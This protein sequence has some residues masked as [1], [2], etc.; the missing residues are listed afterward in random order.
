MESVTQVI[1]EVKAMICDKYCKYPEQWDEETEGRPLWESD[2]CE[3][4][5]LTRL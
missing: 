5:P 4:C 3:N 1:E 2:I